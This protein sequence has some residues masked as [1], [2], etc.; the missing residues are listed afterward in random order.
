MRISLKEFST[1][2]RAVIKIL[3]KILDMLPDPKRTIRLARQYPEKLGTALYFTLLII[4]TDE[5]DSPETDI[6]SSTVP[7]SQIQIE[8]KLGNR[9]FEVVGFLRTS[10]IGISWSEIL[11]RTNFGNNVVRPE[12]WSHILTYSGEMPDDLWKYRLLGMGTPQV[13]PQS[14]QYVDTT[15]SDHIDSHVIDGWQS[16]P[17][18]NNNTYD[19]RYLVLRYVDQSS[20]QES[21]E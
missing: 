21:P 13:H 7:H 18:G 12:D 8:F 14:I 16:E 19:S 5:S 11:D 15:T 3:P 10:E 6:L 2:S 20:V 17:I 4:D 9:S 1:L